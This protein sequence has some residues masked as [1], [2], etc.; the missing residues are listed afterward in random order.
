MRQIMIHKFHCTEWTGWVKRLCR[1]SC[2][3]INKL[4]IHIF[5][6]FRNI[7]EIFI[8]LNMVALFM[9]FLI[10]LVYTF[11]LQIHGFTIYQFCL[12]TS[13]IARSW[14]YLRLTTDNWG[15]QTY[16]LFSGRSV[17]NTLERSYLAI[18]VQKGKLKNVGW[19]EE[20]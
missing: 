10:C 7:F 19:F 3:V 14:K 20:F 5:L 4:Y 9:F 8:T 12:I 11:W 17:Q 1:F 6:W 15:L 18:A 16:R 13:S 2:F